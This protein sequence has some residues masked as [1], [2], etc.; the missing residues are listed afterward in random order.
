MTQSYDIL[1]T[2]IEVG[3]TIVISEH[4]VQTPINPKFIDLFTTD[5]GVYE[6]VATE[7]VP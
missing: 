2:V 3:D 6:L 4:E 1:V 5:R 7:T